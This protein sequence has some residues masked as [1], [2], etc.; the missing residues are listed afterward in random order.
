MPLKYL[1]DNVWA[2]MPKTATLSQCLWASAL[3]GGTLILLALWFWYKGAGGFQ[4][5]IPASSLVMGILGV[6]LGAA[7]LIPGMNVSVYLNSL[8]FLAIFGFVIGRT[9]LS[10]SFYLGVTP[11]AVALRLGGKDFLDTRKPKGTVPQWTPHE[12]KT[13]PR[14]YYRLS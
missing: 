13:D 5:P 2:H 14:R 3:W 9:L 6:I 10:V 11:M 4:G 1:R 8:K 7:L 12:G